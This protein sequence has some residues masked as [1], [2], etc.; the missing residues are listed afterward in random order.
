MANG[1]PNGNG[2]LSRPNILMYGL[3]ALVGGGGAVGVN[4]AS[5]EKV[6]GVE[7]RVDSLETTQAVILE[8]VENIEEKIDDAKD[9]QEEILEILREQ[10]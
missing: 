2:Y 8:K 10:R 9:N 6:D 7:R 3:I 5:S 4:Q 1:K